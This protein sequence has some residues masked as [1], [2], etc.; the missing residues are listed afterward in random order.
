MRAIRSPLTLAGFF[1]TALAVPLR[2]QPTGDEACNA[3]K[4]A[5]ERAGFVFGRSQS[6][7]GLWID[8]ISPIVEGK[9]QPSDATLPLPQIDPQLGPACKAADPDFAARHIIPAS[10][11]SPAPATGQA[12]DDE[13]N[14]SGDT[15]GWY[16]DGWNGPGWYIVGAEFR[17][18]VGF[19]GRE[20]WH[21]WRHG[22]SHGH[23][24]RGA[25]GGAGV[26]VGVGVHGSG[27]AHGGASHAGG[28][29]H[30]GGGGHT[31]GG[32]HGGGGHAGGG[33]HGGGHGGGGGHKHSDIRLKHDIVILGRL[34]NGLGFYR[35]SYNGSDKTYVGVMAQEVLAIMPRA[36]ARDNKGYLLVNYD[37]LG[38]RMQTWDA[39]VAAG[40]RIPTVAPPLDH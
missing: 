1:L 19:G 40:K 15:Y 28:G 3:I 14:W 18:G 21:G 16:D 9:P 35:F 39:W 17:R 8:C 4:A 33:H 32:H 20:G 36:V 10:G 38:L 37:Q 29:H 13:F 2:A 11:P 34:Q 7:S 22:G 26:H 25:R 30:A 31:G 23:G 24:G 12:A 27:A 5:C 6:G